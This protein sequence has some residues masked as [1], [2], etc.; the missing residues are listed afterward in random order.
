[1][2]IPFLHNVRRGLATNSSSS[3]SL[4]FHASPVADD[5][6]GS[7]AYVDTEFGWDHF[8]L[9]S[10]G[11]KLMYGLT[12]AISNYWSDGVTPEYIA[13][14]KKEWGH[15]FPEF[16][17]DDALW[18]NATNGYVDHQSSVG[19]DAEFIA[20][21]RDPRVVVHGGN[22]NGG[23]PY[24]SWDGEDDNLPEGATREDLG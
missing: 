3:H 22:D 10:L 17:G 9:D 11:E 19:V 15:L 13:Q 2:K 23:Y 20:K 16:M 1:M 18:V 7:A 6:I 12:Q 8:V 24:D 21:L 14:M 4:V 5:N